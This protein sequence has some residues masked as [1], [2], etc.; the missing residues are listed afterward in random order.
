M[1]A[2]V[3]CARTM[4]YGRAQTRTGAQQSKAAP[5]RCS[6]ACVATLVRPV[7]SSSSGCAEQGGRRDSCARTPLG[8]VNAVPPSV[9]R[10]YRC[11][12][13]RCVA[14][15][16]GAQGLELLFR[17]NPAMPK[18]IMFSRKD[19]VLPSMKVGSPAERVVNVV[20]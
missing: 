14:R 10:Q 16:V 6:G 15:Q 4:Q 17:N 8:L 9:A 7:A 11:H 18:I 13:V 3:Q 1:H 5:Y 12:A 19:E 20:F 2:L